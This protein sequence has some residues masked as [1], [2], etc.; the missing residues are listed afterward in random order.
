MKIISISES[1]KKNKRF[2]VYLEDGNHYD[3]GLDTGST[4]IDHH[5]KKKRLAYIARHLGNLSEKRLIDSMTPSP[6]LF[7]MVLLWGPYTNI[8]YNI[9][10]LN[11]NSRLIDTRQLLNKIFD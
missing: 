10:F 3:F 5:D 6:A 9:E 8:H 4:Y 7:S 1:P 2:R 11:E